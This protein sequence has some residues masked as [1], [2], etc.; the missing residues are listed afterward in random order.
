[1]NVVMMNSWIGVIAHGVW[2][3]G[4]FKLEALFMYVGSLM[5]ELNI[6]TFVPHPDYIPP[7][8]PR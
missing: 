4:L 2:G 5:R 7:P 6:Q 8:E 1:M 3:V